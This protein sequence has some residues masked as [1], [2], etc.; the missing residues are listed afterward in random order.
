MEASAEKQT[1]GKGPDT[2]A[3][4]RER[5]GKDHEFS[6]VNDCW[7]PLRLWR[8]SFN[9]ATGTPRPLVVPFPSSTSHGML[10]LE[11]VPLRTKMTVQGHILSHSGWPSPGG[12]SGNSRVG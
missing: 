10:F 9:F 3:E 8:Q 4:E 1:D 11:T 2:K 12:D 7:S 5:H 6:V